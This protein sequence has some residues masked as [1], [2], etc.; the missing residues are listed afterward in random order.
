MIPSTAPSLHVGNA[1]IHWNLII[2]KGQGTDKISSHITRLHYIEGLFHLLI[3]TGV[4][5]KIILLN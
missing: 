5:N 2:T 3:L 4:K 1:Y